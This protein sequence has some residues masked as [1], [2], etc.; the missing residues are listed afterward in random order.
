[1]QQIPIVEK[2]VNPSKINNKNSNTFVA[3]ETIFC[4]NPQNICNNEATFVATPQNCRNIL[5][6]CAQQNINVFLQFEY[7]N[8]TSKMCKK[9]TC[10]KHPESL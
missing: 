7:T 1:M 9:K 10:G 4:S 6:L 3:F 5:F 2:S 8:E